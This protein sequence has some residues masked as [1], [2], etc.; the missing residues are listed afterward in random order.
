M[1]V[2]GPS[3]QD[4]TSNEL[5][6]CFREIMD[7]VRKLSDT[8]WKA[9]NE[10]VPIKFSKLQFAALCTDIVRSVLGCLLIDSLLLSTMERIGME[11]VLL[12]A[13]NLKQE[14]GDATTSTSPAQMSPE[15]P[16]D[17]IDNKAAEV[18]SEMSAA[19]KEAIRR[20]ASDKR[21]KGRDA[22][23]ASKKA[24]FGQ[25]VQTKIVAWEMPS[26]LS[27]SLP[28]GGGQSKVLTDSMLVDVDCASSSNVGKCSANV[29][30]TI[31]NK[32][33]RFFKVSK[34]TSPDKDTKQTPPSSNE[35]AKL[36][37]QGTLGAK[38]ESSVQ[39]S[40]SS[41]SA[42]TTV[43]E[44]DLLEDPVA[45]V[46]P[47]VPL[48]ATASR[49]VEDTP[50]P[51]KPCSSARRFFRRVQKRVRGFVS[52]LRR[53][54]SPKKETAS[55]P[56]RVHRSRSDS[57]LDTAWVRNVQQKD[58]LPGLSPLLMMFVEES[59]RRLLVDL[60]R[61]HSLPLGRSDLPNV[62]EFGSNDIGIYD[63]FTVAVG[64][65]TQ[66]LAHLVMESF[67]T[68]SGEVNLPG[69]KQV[70]QSVISDVCTVSTKP[71]RSSTPACSALVREPVG[72]SPAQVKDTCIPDEVPA[73]VE[74]RGSGLPVTKMS[75]AYKFILSLKRSDKVHPVYLE[76]VTHRRPLSG[77]LQEGSRGTP[78]VSASSSK[79]L[80]GRLRRMF[81]ALS[82][83]V[84]K[85]FKHR[86][87]PAE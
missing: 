72:S 38:E 65:L 64:G 51:S 11:E 52:A 60:L 86:S 23:V 62:P 39:S 80:R 63:K 44:A 43:K 59:I 21:G 29:F 50:R 31:K 82:K 55:E 9:L 54:E 57:I 2:P 75:K 20:V 41:E 34:K 81:S 67:K 70:D 69:V 19:M 6:R 49:F 36:S 24:S 17:R 79:K 58:S 16:A 7:A 25:E 87:T 26:S 77:D 83:A 48:E 46:Q 12:V 37:N 56:S 32:V 28:E 78:E 14:L 53:S 8:D 5:L 76:S 4:S 73:P 68:S 33:T 1:E 35:M 18:F 30:K 61:H 22:Q 45:D 74:K 10:G 40:T 84:P 27:D 47:D 3:H 85:P 66:T 15:D 71:G 42:S 13:E